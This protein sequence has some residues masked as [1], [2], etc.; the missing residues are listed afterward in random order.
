[1][2]RVEQVTKKMR[3]QVVLNDVSMEVPDGTIAVVLG[4]SGGGKSVLLKII[5]GLL[6]P[7][8]G[9]VIYDNQVLQFGEF[10]DNE[11]ILGRIGFVFQGGA[12]F[13]WLNVTENVALPLRERAKLHP[14]EIQERVLSALARVGMAEMAGLAIQEL[15]GGMVRLV[16]IA[17]ALVHD[18]DYLFF[19]EPTAGLDP[20]TRER[21]CQL[22][23]DVCRERRRTA[24]IVTHD[25][26]TARF[27]GQ[28]FYLLKGTRL[29]DAVDIKKEDYEPEMA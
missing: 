27:L 23:A 17:R 13:D 15:S 10:A 14:R 3:G 21:V 1:M 20:A 26:D 4:P 6:P 25:L 29:K 28:R 5:A 24:L 12:L 18:P 2:I 9:R 8:S 19:D 11:D 16:A 7:D 22:I